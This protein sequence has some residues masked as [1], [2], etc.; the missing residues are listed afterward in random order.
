MSRDPRHDILFEPV[1]IGPK[2]LRNRFYQVP[3]C[4]GFGVEKPWSQARHRARQGRGRLGGGLHRVLHRSAP[5][6]TRR[7]TCRRACGTTTT[8]ARCGADLRRGARARRARRHRA[9]AHRRARR[10]QRVAAAAAG[11]L[12]DRERLRRGSRAEARW[13]QRDIRPRAGRLGRA[14]PSARAAPA[15]T[16]S[17]STA[18]T[19]TCRDSSS[20]RSTTG[21]PTRT[22]ARSR[23]ARASGSRR[24]RRCA[25]PS[26]T[27]ARSPAGSPW[28]RIGGA[29]ASSSRRGSSSCAWPTTSSTSGTSPSGSIAEWSLDSG[30]SRFFAEG[31][32]LEWTAR[33]REA[34]AKPIVGVGRLTDPDLMAEIVRSG[35]WDLIGAARP[36]IADPFLPRKID[37]G[38]VRRDPRVHRLQ[39]LH[40]QGRQPAPP[41]LHPERDRRRGAP[42]RLAPRA[43][44]AAADPGSRRARGRRR[45]GRHGVR[46]RCSLAA[47]PRACG[48]STRA[49]RS[50]VTS[51]W[52][53][54]LPGLARVGPRHRLPHGRAQAPAERRARERLRPRPPPSWSATGPTRS[55]WRPASHWSADGLNGFT[56]A[57]IPGADARRTS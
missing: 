30:P 20:R 27:T 41:R 19:P 5:S 2:T 16:S 12:A 1:Q 48:S 7:R 54:R 38:R 40:L 8:C 51:G 43:L 24:S 25:R 26:A 9:L 52:V 22:A 10:E 53:T 21:A 47:A 44:R 42:P 45:A 33:V 57:P 37:E 29:R 56:R 23:T 17:T 6:P 31:W 14:R 11:A 3:H 18:R 46:D 55:C 15:S 4:T 50:A 39:R 34:T 28:T 32:Q 13:T 35:V 36:S 49:P